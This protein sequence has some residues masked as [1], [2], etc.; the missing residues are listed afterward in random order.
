MH[1][2]LR[3]IASIIGI[4]IGCGIVALI[5]HNVCFPGYSYPIEYT[6][7]TSALNAMYIVGGLAFGALFFFSAPSVF[8]WLKQR[9][10]NVENWLHNTPAL[11]ILFGTLGLILG[12]VLAYLVGLVFKSIN[13][14]VLPNVLTVILCVVLGYL[15]CRFGVSRGKEVIAET[16]RG[17]ADSARPKVLDTSAII[18]GRIC[19]VCRT[20]FLEG[21]LVIPGFVLKELRHIADSSDAIRRNRGRYGLDII[22]TMQDSLDQSV[23]IIERDYDDVDEVDQKLIRLAEELGGVLVTNDYNL[24]K[25][26]TVQ[27]VSVMNIND[28]ANSVK[29]VLLPGDEVE[30]SI[31]KEGKENGQGVGYLDDGT[32]VIIEG[33]REHIGEKR[34]IIVTSSLQTSAGRMIFAKISAKPE[35][36]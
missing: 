19:D 4:G 29:P 32:M 16:K 9:K 21:K 14:P 17:K 26:A 3:I 15:G 27:Q 30:I 31:M 36:E 1:K 35:Q 25:V 12:L 28:L 18:D 6:T 13:I 20:G 33:G 24:N 2:T 34:N 5:A 11:D 23:E 8:N 10:Q 22:Q 7:V